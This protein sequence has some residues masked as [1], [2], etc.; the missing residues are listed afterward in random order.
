MSRSHWSDRAY[1][2]FPFACSPDPVPGARLLKAW[3]LDDDDRA[4]TP[5]SFQVLDPSAAGEVLA[6]APSTWLLT[7]LR[8]AVETGR[9]AG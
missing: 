7:G 2:G 5:C 9:R 1:I 3:K 4:R 6:A 8:D